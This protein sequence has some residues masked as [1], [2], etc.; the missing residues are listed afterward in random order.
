MS[1]RRVVIAGAGSGVGKTTI[2]T[3]LM[4]ILSKKFRVQGFKVGPDF[5]D[6]MFHAAAT[7]RPSRNLDSFMLDR[8]T[9]LNVFGWATRDADIAIIEGVRGLYDGLT[10][11]GD[12]GSTAE[13]AKLLDASVVL[14]VN[15]RSLAKSA[16]AHVLGFKNLDPGVRIEGVILNYV[17]GERHK[18]K[19]VEAVESLAKTEV[20]G[21]IERQSDRLPERHLGLVTVPE[22][23]DVGSVL[24]LTSDLASDVDV[25]RLLDISEKG[26]ETSFP[27]E[28]PFKTREKL[29][30]KIAIPMDRAFSFY[31]PE[32]IEAVEAAGAEIVPF[33]PTEGDHLP[34]ADGYYL[35]GGYPEVYAKEIYQ[36]EDFLQG[37]KSASEEG[38]LIC[39]ECGGMM[40]LTNAIE[41][42]EERW[43]MA[44][45]FDCE[46]ELTDDRQ[47]LAYV[48][49][50]GTDE[51]FLFPGAEIRGHEFHYSRLAQTPSGPFGYRIQRGVGID[52]KNDGIIRR[53]TIGTYFHQHALSNKAWG[54]AIVGAA[55]Q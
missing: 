26:K 3:G 11:T 14:V 17:S 34:D 13:I 36:N 9:I 22:K 20:I 32:N 44:G 50:V 16:A 52:G 23:E 37:L 48:R 42:R 33:A 47:G 24:R 41:S 49:A 29:G 30:V 2:A 10:S 8:S 27:A 46:A 25:D 15:A 51:N 18:R 6:P 43:K 35:G 19:A 4:S 5:I 7:G 45:I 21:V 1:V 31:Y 40:V 53:R 54:E 12:T 55:S 39:G 38:R 28:S